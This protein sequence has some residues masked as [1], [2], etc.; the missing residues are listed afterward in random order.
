MLLLRGFPGARLFSD[1]GV[2]ARRPQPFSKF[3]RNTP[4]PLPALSAR[5]GSAA[6]PKI[7]ERLFHRQTFLD[8]A[9][10]GETEIS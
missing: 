9:G 2:I 8:R 5:G 1:R 6:A 10:H 3:P 7:L 4:R